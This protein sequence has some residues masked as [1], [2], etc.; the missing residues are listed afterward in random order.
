MWCNCLW[1]R[2]MTKRKAY[3][4]TVVESVANWFEASSLSIAP[5]DNTVRAINHLG[6]VNTEVSQSSLAEPVSHRDET[7]RQALQPSSSTGE[8]TNCYDVNQRVAGTTWT[9]VI[10]G[11]A[12]VDVPVPPTTA[13]LVGSAT[14]AHQAFWALLARAGYEEW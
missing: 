14:S 10:R 2:R 13:E 6:F 9:S 8:V 12:D 3:I 1:P 5:V 4:F 11:Q 7:S